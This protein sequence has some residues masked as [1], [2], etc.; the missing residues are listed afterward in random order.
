[1]RSRT[2]KIEI[3]PTSNDANYWFSLIDTRTAAAFLGMSPR[4]LEGLRYLGGS[5]PY[6]QISPR[7]VRYRRDDLRAWAEERS[8]RN[9]S[10]AA[11]P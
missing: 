9:T 6:L 8:R 3:D 10:E 7:C 5:P 1:M 11:L 4:R 2:A